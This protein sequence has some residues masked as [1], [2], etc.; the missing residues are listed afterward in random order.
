MLSSL[1]VGDAAQPDLTGEPIGPRAWQTQLALSLGRQLRAGTLTPRGSNSDSF[2]TRSA[3]LGEQLGGL[4]K[5]V[6]KMAEVF[7]GLYRT[8]AWAY[9]ANDTMAFQVS[10][11]DYR[12]FGYEPHYDNLPWKENYDAAKGHEERFKY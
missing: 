11:A 12:A 2:G 1:G 9:V 3:V 6:A 7:G 5:D 8:I 10:E 4:S